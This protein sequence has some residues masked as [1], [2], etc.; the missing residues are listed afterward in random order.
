MSVNEKSLFR[1]E[2]CVQFY[3]V[4]DKVSLSMVEKPTKCAQHREMALNNCL[5]GGKI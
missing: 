1:L 5:S 3:D 2:S 4:V